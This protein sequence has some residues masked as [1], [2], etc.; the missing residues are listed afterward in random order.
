MPKINNTSPI[1]GQ[2]S[3]YVPS[4]YDVHKKIRFLTPS[5]PLSTC[6]IQRFIQHLLKRAIAKGAP[7]SSMVKNN[8]FQWIIECVKSVLGKIRLYR[9][10][11]EGDHSTP[12][13][14]PKTSAVLHD[15]G[16]GK[17]D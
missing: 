2:L 4:I 7:D 5:S 8:G 6:V 13:G 15:S 9:L 11:Q 1:Y 12:S 10:A 16:M 3:K 17:H 14:P